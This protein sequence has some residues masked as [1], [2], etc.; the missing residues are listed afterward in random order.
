MDNI[1]PIDKPPEP[2]P[3]TNR[4]AAG[5]NLEGTA[6]AMN[7]ALFP[8][9]DRRLKII[10]ER[11]NP[12]LDVPFKRITANLANDLLE[13]TLSVR[14]VSAIDVQ[15]TNR[16]TLARISSQLTVPFSRKKPLG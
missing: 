13:T 1:R 16:P 5:G 9:D 11:K 15:D 10:A 12:A 6:K 2:Y 8:F 14:E 4:Y 7:L 3:R